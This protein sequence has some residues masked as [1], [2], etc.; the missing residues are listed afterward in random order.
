MTHFGPFSL[1]FP[2]YRFIY[3][4][5]RPKHLFV[6][7]HMFIFCSFT[8]FTVV[9]FF[10]GTLFKI[11]RTL[12]RLRLYHPSLVLTLKGKICLL[13][14]IHFLGQVDHMFVP[15]NF[16]GGKQTL[17]ASIFFLIIL[18]LLWPSFS[19]VGLYS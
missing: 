13:N 15:V 14:F 6:C 18:L 10:S 3:S 8:K 1:F 12:K 4:T 9:L 7:S 17:K 16:C 2:S 11:I 5:Q 19:K